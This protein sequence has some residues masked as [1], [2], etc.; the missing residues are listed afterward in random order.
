LHDSGKVASIPP[1]EIGGGNPQLSSVKSAKITFL[2]HVVRKNLQV[3]L[4]LAVL[5]IAMGLFFYRLDHASLWSDEL[6]SAQTAIQDSQWKIWTAEHPNLHRSMLGCLAPYYSLLRFWSG[7]WGTSEAGLRSLSAFCALLALGMILFLGPRAWGLDARATLAAGGIFALS[8]MMLW[9]AQEARYY[10]LL[11]PLALLDCWFCL[12]FWETRDRRWLAAWTSCAV[13]SV[14]THPYL[15]FVV[16][17]LSLYGLWQWVQQRFPLKIGVVICHL[18]IAVVF[19]AM[20]RA[21]LATSARD[22][23]YDRIAAGQQIAYELPTDEFMFWKVLA[24]FLCGPYAHPSVIL[25]TILLLAATA[26]W[27]LHL[28]RVA[29]G[30]QSPLSEESTANRV[31]ALWLWASL[32]ACVLMIAASWAR[33][34]M[35]E[36][37]RYVMVFFA[38]FCVS[39]GLALTSRPVPRLVAPTFLGVL[40]LNALLTDWAYF[41][42]PQK[43]NWRLAG[44]IIRVGAE[45]GDVWLHQN[46]SRAFAHDYYVPDRPFI[47]DVVME[48]PALE[49]PLPPEVLKARR[50]WMVKTGAVADIYRA[51]LEQVG[52]QMAL[53]RKLP[54]GTFF[55]TWIWLFERPPVPPPRPPAKSR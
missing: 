22:S 47:R 35:V 27:I 21:L 8:P 29:R 19:L 32:G 41:N 25:T 15:I 37:K 5:L 9:Y 23:A 30:I 24:N 26:V 10:A 3:G 55:M 51:N 7:I 53:S 44:Q 4:S 13:L 49:R 43:Q 52:F 17:G 16:V 36:G 38:P 40:A 20:L 33:P 50:I 1:Q 45:E 39:M 12:R 31:M 14:I 42:D 6:V 48:V 28:D 34:F 54:S 46:P 18:L 11:Q 2:E